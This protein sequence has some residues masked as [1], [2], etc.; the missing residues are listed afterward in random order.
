[1]KNNNQDKNIEEWEEQQYNEDM[2]SRIYALSDIVFKYIFGT[3]ESTT[4]LKAFVNAVLKNAH[5]P[6]ISDIEIKNPF[7]AK[8]FQDAKLSIIDIRARGSNHEWYNVEVQIRS[9]ASFQERSLYYWA[10]TYSD[11]LSDGEEYKKLNPV[12]SISVLDF[13]L[14][15]EQ[16]P[17]HSCYMLTEK[18]NPDYVL[19]TD[20]VMHYLEIPKMKETLDSDILRWLYFLSHAGEEDETM[21]VLLKN[22]VTLQEAQKRY[23]NF[24]KDEQARL[25]YQARSMFLHDQASLMGE[26]REEGREEGRSSA[27]KE[28]ARRMKTMGMSDEQIAQALGLSVEEIDKI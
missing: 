22:D 5:F 15:P 4:L 25:A 17:F 27:L 13:I 6:E 20:C 16:I 7:N 26:E 2:S 28:S 11:Q 3:E 23:N 8:T 14:F 9:Q 18:D 19:T 1:M 12:I 21:Y 10:K 24:I